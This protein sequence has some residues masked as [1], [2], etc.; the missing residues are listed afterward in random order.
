MLPVLPLIPADRSCTEVVCFER[1]SA[2]HSLHLRSND[3]SGSHVGEV[4]PYCASNKKQFF[5]QKHF[6]ITRLGL[7]G[8]TTT[9]LR[10]DHS[11]MHTVQRLF[12]ES[13]IY[14]IYYECRRR[15][16]NVSRT[17]NDLLRFEL[18]DLVRLHFYKIP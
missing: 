16:G 1:L 3:F 17:I 4:L 2:L 11:D 13:A 10:L 14:C 9:G 8:S 12:V 5:G 6:P 15:G 7:S 18:N